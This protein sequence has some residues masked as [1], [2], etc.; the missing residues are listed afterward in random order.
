VLTYRVATVTQFLENKV[1]LDTS[2]PVKAVT[3]AIAE[4]VDKGWELFA[5]E[6]IP[7]SDFHLTCLLTFRKEA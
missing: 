2:V 7:A 6:S 4:W 1:A 3:A 5:I